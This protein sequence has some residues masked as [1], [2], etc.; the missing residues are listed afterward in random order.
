VAKAA[1]PDRGRGRDGGRA[2]RSLL[3]SG[4]LRAATGVA[5][6]MFSRKYEDRLRRVNP[7]GGV[8]AGDRLRNIAIKKSLK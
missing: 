3:V 7:L 4:G 8:R 2:R 1:A 5:T 6:T